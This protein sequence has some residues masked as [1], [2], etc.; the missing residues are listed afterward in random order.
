MILVH[1]W[2]T[3][4]FAILGAKAS[5]SFTS[6]SNEKWSQQ[7][8]MTLSIRGPMDLTMRMHMCCYSWSQL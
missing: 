2:R 4:G 6:I 1:R 3:L 8:G 5:I 7:P